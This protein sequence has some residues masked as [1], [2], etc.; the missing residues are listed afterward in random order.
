MGKMAARNGQ[1]PYSKVVIKKKHE[2][3]DCCPRLIKFYAD[4]NNPG[5]KSKT[6]RNSI[7]RKNSP[8]KRLLN[9]PSMKTLHD[10]GPSSKASLNRPSIM[11][12]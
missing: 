12:S 4:E 6:I 1:S 8:S 5:S 7:D 2:E 11:S 10:K 3:K 9:E